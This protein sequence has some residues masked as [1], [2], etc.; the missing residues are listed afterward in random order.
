M[1]QHAAVTC[2]RSKSQL[3]PQATVLLAGL[4]MSGGAVQIVATVWVQVALLLQQVACQTWEMSCVQQLPLVWGGKAM[5]VTLLQH[6][7]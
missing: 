3:V 4:V 1:G 7:A 2:G 6:G 5:S